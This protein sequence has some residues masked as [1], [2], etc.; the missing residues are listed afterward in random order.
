MQYSSRPGENALDLFGG[1]GSTL[2]GAKKTGRKFYLMEIDT[3]YCDVIAD[4]FQRFTGK[5]AVLERTGESP[6]PIKP[7]EANMR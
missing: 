2:I 4:R 3:L 7:H 5:P 1:S 6:L